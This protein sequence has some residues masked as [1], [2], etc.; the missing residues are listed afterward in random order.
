[1]NADTAALA[2]PNLGTVERAAPLRAAVRYLWSGALIIVL[3]FLVLYPVAMLLLGA[4]TKTNPVVDGF[5]VF[6]LSL[7][8][9]TAVLAN[10]NVRLAL[11]NSL[12]ACT[13]GTALAVLI[14]L[15]FA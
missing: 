6:D 5:G 13:G 3:G 8:N 4:L 15:A 14:G 7:A 10:E 1:M 9:F 12:V 11:W 2:A